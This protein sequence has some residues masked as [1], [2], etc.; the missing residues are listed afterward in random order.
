[1]PDYSKGYVYILRSTNGLI[2]IGSSTLTVKKRLSTHRNQYKALDKP[3]CTSCQL[4]GDTFIVT[5]DVLEH[6]PCINR[7]Q[8]SIREQYH[9]D[10][11][12]CVNKV[13]PGRSKAESAKAWQQA[14]KDYVNAK[15]RAWREK[16]KDI[17]QTS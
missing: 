6:Y 5:I 14:N 3:R 12:D 11:Y 2:Y 16:H 15:N 13:M 10:R 17:N 9:I 1:M 8:L 4:F 7:K